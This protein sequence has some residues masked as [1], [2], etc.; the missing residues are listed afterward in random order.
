M[1]FKILKNLSR[2]RLILT[3]G[4]F[5]ALLAYPQQSQALTANEI[6]EHVAARDKVLQ[7][8]RRQFDYTIAITVQKLDEKGKI[9]SSKVTNETVIGDKRPSYTSKAEM[10]DPHAE[11]LQRA[12]DD[13][14]KK[15]P[16]S[17]LNVISHFTF[18]RVCEET[19]NGELAYKIH[20][21]PKPDMPYHSREEKVINRVEGDLW[22]SESD[23]SLLRNQ[24]A[25]GEPISIAWFFATLRNMK[26]RFDAQR[27]PNGDFGPE[28]VTYEFRVMIPFGM[29]HERHT[30]RMSDFELHRGK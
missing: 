3:L 12:A 16:F 26:Y 25:L 15:E 28:S 1:N 21:K 7:A 14:S 11:S 6:V 13:Q 20:Y 17:L 9:V 22:A 18:T 29:I 10:D 27:L 24:G 23:F 5:A 8:R 4:F 2:N 30:R 19:V